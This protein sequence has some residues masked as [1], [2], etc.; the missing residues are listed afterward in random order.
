MTLPNHTQV[1]LGPPGTGKTTTLLVI[2]NF[3][4][5]LSLPSFTALRVKVKKPMFVGS[6]P[7]SNSFSISSNSVVVFPSHDRCGKIYGEGGAAGGGNGGGALYVKNTASYD[8]VS[9]TLG[10]N[11]QIWA[12]GGGGDNGN[13]GNS[14]STISCF[15]NSNHNASYNQNGRN[16]DSGAASNTCSSAAPL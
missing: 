5:A 6:V 13:S 7:D 12:G 15:T 9:V 14:G 8:N 10:S 11:G 1:I 4:I 2:P 16:Y 3:V